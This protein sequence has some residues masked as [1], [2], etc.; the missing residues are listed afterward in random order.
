MC[1]QEQTALHC[2]TATFPSGVEYSTESSSLV[3]CKSI[4]NTLLHMSLSLSLC[5][6]SLLLP[7]PFPPPLP[8]PPTLSLL[9]SPSQH[10]LPQPTSDT[11]PSPI[12]ASI[13]SDQLSFELSALLEEASFLRSL[14][15]AMRMNEVEE[16]RGGPTQSRGGGRGKWISSLLTMGTGSTHSICLSGCPF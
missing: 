7:S 14:E 8:S 9:P 3:E 10:L 2:T 15:G 4:L 11:S 5:W 6:P 1:V 12:C 13:S 16:R